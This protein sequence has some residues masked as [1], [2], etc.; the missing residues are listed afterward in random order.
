MKYAIVATT[1]WLLLVDMQS[2]QVQPLEQN[3]PEYYGIS[4]FPGSEEL[5]LSHTGLNN[6]DLIDIAGY[7]QSERGWLSQGSAS[8]RTFLSAPHQILCAPDG[9]VIC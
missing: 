5:V 9:R 8:S 1:G 6:A 4:W 2:R 3:R 7:A